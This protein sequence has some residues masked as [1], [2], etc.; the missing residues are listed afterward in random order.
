MIK[1][2]R[3]IF[4]IGGGGFSD[5]RV[6]S[7]LDDYLLRIT[8]KRQPRVCFIPTASGDRE[9]YIRRFYKAF[10]SRRTHASCLH[11]FSRDTRDIRKHLLSQD[12]I[13]VGGGNT[14]NMLAVWRTHGVDVVL[15][16]CWMKG[17]VLAGVSAGMLCWFRS[18]CTDS[19]G[20]LA[21][22][23]DGLGFLRGSACPH[24]N[25]EKLRRRA[26]QHL[27]R[28]E[29]PAGYAVDDHAAIHFINEKLFSCISARRGA[30]C[31][32]VENRSGSVVETAL[33]TVSV[34]R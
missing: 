22:L 17:V 5:E 10:S 4:A 2:Q 14:A 15:R 23:H 34:Y 21:P 27:V 7:L 19:Y 6:I 11:L 33:P 8:R 9:A 32:R 24:Y 3:H 26:Y 12:I 1:R 13:Y 29:L 20:T 30:G 28:G 18:G 31:Y 16:E 25:S